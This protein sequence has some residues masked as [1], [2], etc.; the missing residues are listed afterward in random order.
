MDTKNTTLDDLAPIVGFTATIRLT[1]Y[2][3][4]KNM[5]VPKHVSE[6]HV[7]A[8]LIGMSAARKLSVEYAGCRFWVPTL[9]VA[10]IEMRN[11]K[12]LERLRCRVSTDKIAAETGLT[13]RRV[14][15]I[16]AGFESAGFLPEILPGNPDENCP[17]N[18]PENCPENCPEKIA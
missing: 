17:E 9:H 5:T 3:G 6:K 4:G 14:Q 2:Y 11:A 7:L 1:A 15:Q 13:V 18:D 16:R 12:V 10:E 8:K